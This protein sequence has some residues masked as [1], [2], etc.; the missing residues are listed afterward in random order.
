MLDLPWV[1]QLCHDMQPQHRI[2][3]QPRLPLPAICSAPSPALSSSERLSGASL[4]VTHSEGSST[5][6]GLDTSCFY[7]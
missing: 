7:R 4:R 6:P 5:S 2:P 1:G 3:Q